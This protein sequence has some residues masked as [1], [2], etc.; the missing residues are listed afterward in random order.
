M[1]IKSIKQLI[2][3]L[4]STTIIAAITN[5]ICCLAFWMLI[6]NIFISFSNL[7]LN[8]QQSNNIKSIFNIYHLVIV[9]AVFFSINAIVIVLFWYYSYHMEKWKIKKWILYNIFFLFP[10]GLLG[11]YYG[12]INNYWKVENGAV[13]FV[14]N[15]PRKIAPTNQV[16]EIDNQ[17]N[18]H[19]YYDRDKL[20]QKV[21]NSIKTLAKI[22]LNQEISYL[23]KNIFNHNN[24][25]K[26]DFKQVSN[27]QIFTWLAVLNRVPHKDLKDVVFNVT[28]NEQLFHFAVPNKYL[29]NVKYKYIQAFIIVDRELVS[30]EALIK[31]AYDLKA[32]KMAFDSVFVGIFTN[33]AYRIYLNRLKK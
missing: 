28:M 31:K 29:K 20:I 9:L 30:S 4:R 27:T 17:V 11:C 14:L 1:M 16:S 8:P 19:Y 7:S 15:E 21:Q 2:I 18:H 26:I 25:E 33:R 13:D 24:W 23:S 5:L 22:N 10:W 3:L 12:L 32:N 6:A